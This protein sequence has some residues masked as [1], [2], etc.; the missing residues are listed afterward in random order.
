MKNRLRTP[1]EILIIIGATVFFVEFFFMFYNENIAWWF[2]LSENELGVLDAIVIVAVITPS[3]YFLTAKR[4]VSNEANLLLLNKALLLG[5]NKAEESRVRMEALLASLGEGMIATDNNGVV[6]SV[7]HRAEDMLGW[8]KGELVGKIFIEI[9]SAA[10]KDGK[11][12]PANKRGISGAQRDISTE[13]AC[14]LHQDPASEVLYYIQKSGGRLPVS[15]TLTPIILGVENIGTVEIFYDTT[16]EKEIEKT[17]GDL[18]AIASHQLRTPL[19]GTKWLIETLI[20]GVP[21][22]LTPPQTEYLSE[23]YKINER[24]TSLVG[25]MLGVMRMEGDTIPIKKSAVSTTEIIKTALENFN[26]IAK[27]KHITISVEKDS[28]YIV[29]TD[30]LLLR[31][32][33]D[34]LISNAVNYSNI[35]GAVLIGMK[36]DSDEITLSVKD[37]GIGIPKDEQKKLFE[38]FYRASNAKTFNTRGTGLGLY[39][40]S[41]L[42]KKIGARISFESEE[43]KGSTFYVHI[44]LGTFDQKTFLYPRHEPAGSQLTPL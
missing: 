34:C 27:G 15:I 42:A 32:I 40:A 43:G 33:L 17:R 7:S 1:L 29:E 10:D 4:I 25:D 37:S 19:S 16:K 22:P 3:I 24:M 12:I 30:P 18:L 6:T 21:G 14:P 2:S 31:N 5:K 36:K 26:Q 39:I 8:R 28:E 44:P 35:D 13:E 41:L 23:I 38:R 9:V 20:K 11:I